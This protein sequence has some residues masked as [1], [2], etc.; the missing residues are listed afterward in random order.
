M[1][2][3]KPTFD[4]TPGMRV[5]YRIGGEETVG[6]VSNIEGE[7]VELHGGPRLHVSGIWAVALHRDK[8]DFVFGGEDGGE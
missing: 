5:V 4:V 7:C 3:E 1:E 2:S 8:A 6:M